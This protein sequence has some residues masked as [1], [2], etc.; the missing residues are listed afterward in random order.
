MSV[1]A[2]VQP[3][4]ALVGLDKHKIDNFV[5]RYNKGATQKSV[6]MY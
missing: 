2:I 6:R 4:K 3:V 1:V 5:F